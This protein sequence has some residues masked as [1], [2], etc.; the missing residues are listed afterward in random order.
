MGKS[1]SFFR[2]LARKKWPLR[3]NYLLTIARRFEHGFLPGGIQPG[4]GLALPALIFQIC[5]LFNKKISAGVPVPTDMKA[6]IF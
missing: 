6:K 1:L 4:G 3:G 2:D 5:F